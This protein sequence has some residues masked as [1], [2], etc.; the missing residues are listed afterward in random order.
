ME[1]EDQ[2]L[3]WSGG[4]W[5][6][7]A[8]CAGG[9]QQASGTQLGRRWQRRVGQPAA[10]RRAA[11]T[12][13]R[14]TPWWAAAFGAPGG[15][16]AARSCGPAAFGA[17]PGYAGEATS[18][19]PGP[20]GDGPGCERRIGGRRAE[21]AARGPRVSTPSGTAAQVQP[22]CWQPGLLAW[23]RAALAHH[24]RLRKVGRRA[25]T[26]GEMHHH[27]SNG[28]MGMV[29]PRARLKAPSDDIAV[30]RSSLSRTMEQASVMADTA[31]QLAQK[32]AAL[33]RTHTVCPAS[34]AAPGPLADPGRAAAGPWA[35]APPGSGRA[36]GRGDAAGGAPVQGERTAR[37]GGHAGGGPCH[38]ASPKNTSSRMG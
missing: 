6:Q 14:G 31:N 4:L 10:A 30:L 32:L 7:R 33:V 2:P 18:T 8:G 21:A 25:F 15:S 35:A 24:L 9:V 23:H 19:A 22:Q 11:S 12:R 16:P 26:Q 38:A 1:W 13:G 27:L 17:G 5:G 34:D 36:Q 20:P 37:P 28:P 29:P 3:S